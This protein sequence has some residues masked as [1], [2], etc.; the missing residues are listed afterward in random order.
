MNKEQILCSNAILEEKMDIISNKDK[1]IVFFDIDDT[2]YNHKI[3]VTEKARF[4][5][6]KLREN[7]HL[8]FICTGRSKAMIFPFIIEVGFDGI[9]A[10][11]GT[12]AEYDGKILMRHDMDEEIVA[13]DVR[14]LR[15]CGFKTVPEGHDY[16]YYEN[17]DTWDATYKAVYGLF[18]ENVGD[19]MKEIPQD[20][21]GMCAAKIS[22][23]FTAQ[24]DYKKAVE[25]F[26]EDYTVVNHGNVLLELIPKGFSKAE[27][28]KKLIEILGIPHENTYAIGDSMNDYEM[29]EY[30]NYGI[31]MGNSDERI[32]KIADYVTDTIEDEGVYNA[33]LHLGLI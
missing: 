9:I 2:I 30:V 16:L 29:I 7:G 32:I 19:S 1:K 27:G 13:R 3:G 28:I 18:M 10:G 14:R 8:A 21:R 11:A 20:E 23:V 12:Y 33:L 22:S 4:A 31:A 25:L 17:I 5:I 24:S 15:E 26:E 6:K